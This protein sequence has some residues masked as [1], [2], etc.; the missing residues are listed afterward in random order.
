M[1]NL[2]TR[3]AYANSQD[4]SEG[5]F[6]FRRKLSTHIG[7]EWSMFKMKDHYRL[8]HKKNL[9]HLNAMW[10]L[11]LFGLKMDCFCFKYPEE[12]RNKKMKL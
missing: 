5:C 4:D 1:H 9:L 7:W 12:Q 6:V 2:A 3:T 8:S 11:L 10:H